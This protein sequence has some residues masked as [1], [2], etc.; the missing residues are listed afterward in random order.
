M[1][2]KR[3]NEPN[4]NFNKNRNNSPFFILDFVFE[5]LTLCVRLAFT[6]VGAV[7]DVL[8]SIFSSRGQRQ[9][10]P[11]VNM[12]MS[13]NPNAVNNTNTTADMN[14]SCNAGSND[15]AKKENLHTANNNPHTNNQSKKEEN[16]TAK[17]SKGKEQV[18][19]NEKNSSDWNIVI[20]I[21]TLIPVIVFLAMEKLILAGTAVV[22]GTIIMILYNMLKGIVN[23][24]K[25]HKEENPVKEEAPK[26]TENSE[27]EKLIKDAFDKVYVIRKNLN[28]V[29]NLEIRS[30]V[31]N[32]CGMSEKII[33]EVRVNPENIRV[34]KKFFYYY[35]D[36]FND[37]F[38]RYLRIASFS[39]SSE[40]I[41]KTITET[42]NSFND[43]EKIFKD[44][45]EDLIESDMMNIKATINVM[46]NS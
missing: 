22:I 19:A 29:T 12:N 39:N 31:D 34:V 36:A 35:L 44:L 18:N 40:E 17:P 43:I 1:S 30:K 20:F 11:P 3:C 37:I 6:V 24:R 4:N 9:Y 16:N 7:F 5:I 33:G 14:R 27:I 15:N 2:R 21:L 41:N 28:K 8:N 45:C 38:N 25:K 42:E 23:A 13:N 26:A 10:K 32:L 46:K